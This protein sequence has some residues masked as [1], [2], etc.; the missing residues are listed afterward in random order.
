M[1]EWRKYGDWFTG[2]KECAAF[3]HRW[4]TFAVGGGSKMT[5]SEQECSRCG[6]SRRVESRRTELPRA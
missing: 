5:F 4:L 6:E 1:S 3:G 2:K